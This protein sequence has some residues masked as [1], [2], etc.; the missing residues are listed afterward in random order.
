[1]GIYFGLGDDDT[2]ERES[3]FYWPFF[4]SFFVVT[5]ADKRRVFRHRNFS[6]RANNRD[7]G[8]EGWQSESSWY[9]SCCLLIHF[10]QLDV[11]LEEKLITEWEEHLQENRDD[12]W[13]REVCDEVDKIA[14][15]MQHGDR[16]WKN[17]VNLDAE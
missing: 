10:P 1:M 17:W 2:D 11:E 4:R 7:L 12:P 3:S 5:N 8:N 9:R 15:V 13:E 14:F 6:G 16:H